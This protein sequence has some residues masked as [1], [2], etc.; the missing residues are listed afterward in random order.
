[1]FAWYV[2]VMYDIYNCFYEIHCIFQ[3][4]YNI[5]S[6]NNLSNS[7]YGFGGSFTEISQHWS[8]RISHTCSRYNN[9]YMLGIIHKRHSNKATRELRPS[10]RLNAH[11]GYFFS[12]SLQRNMGI[13][14]IEHRI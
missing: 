3:F 8:I 7:V 6:S 4:N 12:D 14:F 11:C 9:K 13:G 2:Y 10:Q 5:F 1:M